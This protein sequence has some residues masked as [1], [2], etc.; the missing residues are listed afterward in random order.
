[1]KLI[2]FKLSIII[3]LISPICARLNPMIMVCPRMVLLK[4]VIDVMSAQKD[5][6]EFIYAAMLYYSHMQ[7]KMLNW[8]GW[9]IIDRLKF[10]IDCNHFY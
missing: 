4:Q 9:Y 1:M 2:I 3:V 8:L 10:K 7:L 6:Y 5:D